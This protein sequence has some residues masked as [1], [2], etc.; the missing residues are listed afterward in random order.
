MRAAVAS[1]ISRDA[2]ATAVQVVNR[3]DTTPAPGQVLV[4][5]RANSLNHHDLW[6]RSELAVDH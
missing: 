4:T 3:D 6:R 2:P 1:K 5:V